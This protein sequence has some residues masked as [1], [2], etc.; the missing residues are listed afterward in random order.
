MF[1]HWSN[2]KIKQLKKIEYKQ[3]IGFKP[4]GLWFSKDF[5]WF[6]WCIKNGMFIDESSYC[7]Q[8]DI[9][10][11]KFKI[12]DTIE[13]LLDFQSTY[14]YQEGVLN[15]LEYI[16]WKKVSEDFDGIFFDN[17]VEIKLQCNS[18]GLINKLT[19]FYGIDVSSGVIFNIDCIKKF[20][21]INLN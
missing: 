21:N 13:K 15:K 11:N 8:L 20:E 19:W 9:S 18:R 10:L 3:Y 7:Y 5:D 1:Y 14:K 4:K 2:N 16:N 17:Y 12:I 6:R